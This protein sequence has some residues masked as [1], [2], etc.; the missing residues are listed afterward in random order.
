MTTSNTTTERKNV[1]SP[2]LGSVEEEEEVNGS[3]GEAAGDETA[4]A[5]AD[6]E[7]LSSSSDYDYGTTTTTAANNSAKKK[8]DRNR[9]K[10]LKT[11]VNEH[12]DPGVRRFDSNLLDDL[13]EFREGSIPQSC[14]LAICNALVCGIGCYLY[15]LVLEFG[16]DFFWKTLPEEMLVSKF[17]E[18]RWG[19]FQH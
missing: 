15:Y 2:L 13:I 3:S 19:H 4:T 18:Y 5:T 9:S 14:I 12:L 6:G 11:F 7:L 8:K 17:I 1:L 10:S 16:L